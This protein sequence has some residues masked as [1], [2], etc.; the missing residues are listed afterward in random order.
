MRGSCCLAE[1]TTMREQCRLTASLA[2]K[3]GFRPSSGS[4]TF[5]TTPAQVTAAFLGVFGGRGPFQWQQQV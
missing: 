2:S 4:Q 1:R 5:D 3:R